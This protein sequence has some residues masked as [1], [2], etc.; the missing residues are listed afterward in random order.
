MVDHR[1]CNHLFVHNISGNECNQAF[2][3]YTCELAWWTEWHDSLQTPFN[4][5]V[6]E[7]CSLWVPSSFKNEVITHC[8]NPNTVY[9]D[10][11]T[12][13]RGY[14]QYY[15]AHARTVATS[16][17]KDVRTPCV[18]FLARGLSL[19]LLSST[20]TKQVLQVKTSLVTKLY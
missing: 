8:S 2:Y 17:R 16:K 19:I 20:T 9:Q 3:S 4:N 13:V 5:P 1:P 6:A 14:V 18:P 15:S 7:V 10:E 12:E 11:N